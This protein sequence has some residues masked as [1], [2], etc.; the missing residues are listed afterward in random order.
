MVGNIL[1]GCWILPTIY[2]SADLVNT[3]SNR[4]GCLF[5]SVLTILCSSLL[6]DARAILSV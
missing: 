5:E 6:E 1:G 2:P 4:D 3:L